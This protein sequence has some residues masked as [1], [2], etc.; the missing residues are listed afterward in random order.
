MPRALLFDFDLTLADSTRAIV[1]CMTHAFNGMSLACP[2]A[3]AI[4]RTIGIPLTKAFATLSGDDSPLAAQAFVKRYLQHADQVMAELTTL[5]P[6]AAATAR[7]LKTRDIRTAIVSTK[8]R[9]RIVEILARRDLSDAFD[10]VIGGEDVREHK[11]HPEGLQRALAQLRIEPHDAWYVGD[12]PVDAQAAAGA[13][14]NF[15]AVLTGFTTREDFAAYQVHHFLESLEKLPS[16]VDTA[17]S[18]PTLQG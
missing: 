8:F 4:A 2:T 11:P 18:K 17:L 9:Y 1:E 3:D 7:A 5:L 12:H 14:L 15:V 10:V 13:Q 6:H 16:L